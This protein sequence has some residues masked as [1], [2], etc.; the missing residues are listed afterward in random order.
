MKRGF[1]IIQIRN[2][3]LFKILMILSVNFYTLKLMAQ[4]IHFSQMSF[5][6]INL[7]PALSGAN[8]NNQLTI[9]YKNQWRSISSPYKTIY[10][11]YDQRLTSPKKQ[12]TSNGFWAMGLG[13][14]SDKAGD[15]KMG[16]TS[17]N[18]NIAYHIKIEEKQ[19]LGVAIQPGFANRSMSI[20]NIKWGTQ[21]ET[22]VGYNSSFSSNE[23]VSTKSFNFFDLGAG[24]VYTYKSNE[25]YITAN[26][27]V[28]INMGVATY[29][30]NKP[31]Y[32]F[33]NDPKE[34]LGRRYT[35]F[36]NGQFGVKNSNFTFLPGIYF[37][38]QGKQREVLTGTYF[39]YL[40]QGESHYTG[41]LKGAAI[42][43]G[44]FLR[45][46]DAVVLKLLVEYQQYSF[47]F[48][49]DINTSNLNRATQAK[50]GIEVAIRF[51][52]PNP[53]GKGSAVKFY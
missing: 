11:S 26:D 33:V 14:F 49:Y 1:K 47:G 9:A 51:A 4:D 42:S 31:K 52:S 18:I 38:Q 5:T 28:N 15:S 13:L 22:G 53:F 20:D 24:V 12:L 39:R 41:L 35:A 27:K 8:F 36:F 44:T 29:H 10:A 30:I 40:L 2:Y 16:T 43:F 32:S 7:N 37:N 23:N 17:C 34:K 3:R 6:P 46:K 25:R 21:Y 19:T 50:G 45:T 48:A